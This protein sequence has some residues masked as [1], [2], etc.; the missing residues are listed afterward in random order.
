MTRFAEI[1]SS[2]T[3]PMPGPGNREALEIHGDR[4]V[5]T[6]QRVGGDEA[7]EFAR[8]ARQ[9]A[10][11]LLSALFGNSPYLSHCLIIDPPFAQHLIEDGPEVAYRL[12]LEEIDDR[13]LLGTESRTALMKR[14]R[15]AKRRASLAIGAADI[16]SVWP[17]DQVTEALS[18]LAC[19]ALRASCSNLLRDLHDSAQMALPDPSQPEM[20]SGLIVLGMGKLGA[21]ELNYSS[22]I[23]LIILYDQSVTPFVGKGEIQQLFTRLARNLVALMD[24]RTAD[25]YVFRT[26]LRLRPDP[27]ST[28]PALSTQAAEIYYES[29]GQNWE[30][31]AMIKA[32]PVAGDIAAGETFLDALRPF[33]WRRNLDFAAIQDIQSIKRQIN[34]HRGTHQIGLKGHNV[35][36]GQGGIREIE[37]F[38]QTQQLIWGGRDPSLRNRRTL[39]TLKDLVAAGHLEAST[40]AELTTSYEFLRKLEHRLQMIDDRQTH[41]LPEDD[42]G[43]E[44]FAVFAGF[45]SVDAFSEAFLSQLERVQRNYGALF[46]DEPNLSGSGN[47]V[48]TG[49]DHDPDTLNTLRDMGYAE[50]ERASNMVR[51]WHTGRYGAMRSARARE[52]LTELV[53]TI[54]ESLSR[55]IDPDTALLNF[56][57][58]LSRL[59]SGVPLFSL[60]TARPELFELVAEIMGAAPRLADWL[61]RHP[62][63]LDSILSTEFVN[64]DVPDIDELDSEVTDIARRGLI[65]LYYEREFGIG[66]MRQELEAARSEASNLE[67]FLGAQR[68]WA[69]DRIFQ[70]GVHMLR[71]FFPPVEAGRPLSSIA[72]ACLTTLLPFIAS[73]FEAVHGRVPG[74]RIALVAFG[75]LGSQEMTTT[76]DLDLLF[77]YDHDAD[78]F[79]SD[80]RK[81]LAPAHYFA[82]LYR[83]FISAVTAPTADGRLYEVDMRLRPSGHAG[84]LASSLEAFTLYQKTDAWTWEHQALTRA[85]VIF[86]E[87]DLGERL[88]DI[89]RSVLCTR[90]DGKQLASEVLEMRERMRREFDSKGNGSIKHRRGGLVDVEFIAQFLQLLHGADSPELLLREPASVFRYAETRSFL[91]GEAAS[92]LIDAADLWRNLQGILRLTIG[93][94]H[95]DEATAPGLFKVIC[96]S[97]GTD[98]MDALK[99]RLETTSSVVSKHFASII[100]SP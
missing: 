61:S 60:F 52:L 19:A 5:E 100:E 39:R 25:G 98:D 70:I 32:K 69:N 71:G 40:A 21:G 92:D 62:A 55:S 94:D 23:D 80:G 96:R 84:P 77:V 95:L 38:A 74:S 91:S 51:V 82:Q 2:G 10:E 59:P 6:A 29:S 68:R 56:D 64:L 1:W 35:K 67:D 73:E 93:D 14:L 17:L 34:A 89:I 31:A 37:F 27:G 33:I 85:R 47:L 18:G 49:A 7:A 24:E 4:W 83:R 46:P 75:K 86:A 57:R 78:A 48:F 65:R 97:C 58:F 50:P 8:T 45:P 15:R 87:G 42:E 43:L 36:L 53:P 63:L 72:E 12:A 30:R 88:N 26:D 66:E 81:S 90:R 41:T 20:D 54:L 16:A 11:P 13:S 28:A 99:D 76:S 3:V 44:K 22:D 79:G 9:M